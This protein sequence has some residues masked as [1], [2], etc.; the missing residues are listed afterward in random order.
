MLSKELREILDREIL[1]KEFKGK[2]GLSMLMEY[3][4]GQI[5]RCLK[6]D[7]VQSV[8]GLLRVSKSGRDMKQKVIASKMG[9]TPRTLMEKL[10]ERGVTF[11]ELRDR[12]LR[13]RCE[14]LA[15]FGAPSASELNQILGYA[16]NSHFYRAFRRLMGCSFR[17][18]KNS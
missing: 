2:G 10:K 4:S 14:R 17:E 9:M 8:R 11:S 3:I 6:D 13:D 18:W 7:P 1:D 15:E 16:D 5:Y 12:E